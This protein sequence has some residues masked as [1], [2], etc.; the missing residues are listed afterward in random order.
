MKRRQNSHITLAEEWEI[1]QDIE[2]G[3]SRMEVAVLRRLRESNPGT[4]TAMWLCDV[5]WVL[6]TQG[7]SQSHG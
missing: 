2:R 7:T 1:I 3:L 4:A 6:S 5:P